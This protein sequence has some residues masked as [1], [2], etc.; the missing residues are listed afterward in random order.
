MKRFAILLHFIRFTLIS[1]GV[2]ICLKNPNIEI[3]LPFCFLRIGWQ[4][5]DGNKLFIFTSMKR[6]RE[7][8]RKQAMEEQGIKEL[9]ILK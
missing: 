2:S 5:E 8:L 7:K 6:L 3:H 1:F 4:D 9:K